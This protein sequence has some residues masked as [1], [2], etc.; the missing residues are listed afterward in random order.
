MSVGNHDK[1][2][3]GGEWIGPAGAATITSASTEETLGTVPEASEADVDRAV[4][5]A[6][7]A[8]DTNRVGPPG[9]P[10]RRAEVDRA[11]GRRRGKPGPK[12]W[13][14]PSARRTACP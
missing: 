1:L 5:A 14:R 7:R 6:R 12:R 9:S 8:F 3:T 2:F 11:P 4:A 13:C 10:G